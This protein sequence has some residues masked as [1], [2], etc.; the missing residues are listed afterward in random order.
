MRI[1]KHKKRFYFSALGAAIMIAAIVL[2]GCSVIKKNVALS[3]QIEKK[4]YS[5]G[6]L[7]PLT[8][9]VKNEGV[10][11]SYTGTV[12]FDAYLYLDMDGEKYCIYPEVYKSDKTGP[13]S[14]TIGDYIAV[15]PAE[16]A[17]NTFRREAVYSYVLP[18]TI[19]EDAPR[20]TY[21]ICLWC[22]WKEAVF[23]N[24]IKIE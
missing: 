16:P 14:V 22:N 15:H 20:G 24:A 21:S 17:K 19:P 1:L 10:T 8:V 4:T 18:L 6:E 3:Y 11:F 5:R 2:S 9:L 7:L 13:Y 23:E 12:A